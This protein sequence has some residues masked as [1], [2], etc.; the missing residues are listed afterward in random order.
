MVEAVFVRSQVARARIAHIDTATARRMPGVVTVITASDLV[1][2][3]EPFTRFVDQEETPPGLAKVANPIVLPCPIEPLASDEVRYVGQPIAVVVAESRY[4]AEDAAEVISIEYEELPVIDNPEDAVHG[5]PDLV[6]A[7]LGTNVQASFEVSVGNV[8]MAFESV[9]R[10]LSFKVHVPRLAANPIETRGVVAARDPSSGVLT[11]W[12][13]TQVPYMVRTRIAEQLHLPEET[14]RVVAPDVGGGFG[15]KVNVYPEEV[16]L[17]Y[18]ALFLDRPVRWIEDRQEHLLAAM[19]SRDQVHFVKVGFTDD[20]YI[21]AIED[22]FLLDAGAYNPFSLT[23]AYNTAAHLRGPYKVPNF[24]IKGA[25]VLTNKSPNGPYR[26]AGRP[27]A[28]FVMDKIL[29]LVAAATGL[30]PAEV[31]RRN[32][33][34]PAELPYD[35][36]MPYRD[37]A[38]I[39]YDSGDYPAALNKALELCEYDSLRADQARLKAEGRYVGVGLSFYIEG[40]GLGPFEGSTVRVEGSG[41]V[42]VHAGSTPHGQSH[43]TT[44]AQICADELGVPFASVRVRAGDT[45]LLPYGVGTFASRSLVTAGTAV[46]R[47]TKVVKDKVLAVAAELLEVNPAD[48]VIEDGVIHPLGVPSRAVD[49]KAVAKAASPGP[50]AVSIAGV[51]GGISATSY[52]VP[53]TVTFSYGV[54]AATVEVD[55]ELGTVE[56]LRYIVVHDCGRIVNPLV[57]EGQVQ[58]GVAQGIGSA[59]YEEF[60]YGSGGQ[61][62]TTTFMDYLLPGSTEIPPVTQIHLQIPSPRNELGVKG[63]GEGG[64]IP[65][66][67]AIGNA[68]IDALGA[69][70]VDLPELPFTPERISFLADKIS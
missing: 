55:P 37:G 57:V 39:I 11:V 30:D 23:C 69:A 20:G 29:A 17:P 49:L 33:I 65:P 45:G 21:V 44:L 28:V 24:H 38:R 2:K 58:G 6:H 10:T 19:H 68:I 4:I 1:G 50:R 61:P 8:E 56:I 41:E 36:G 66:P 51:E 16:V 46:A 53:E 3:V 70:A 13:S 48:L 27:E 47:A 35:Q 31:F 40:T 63:V 60:I 7:D 5:Y 54:H 12:S 9:S 64:A 15:P 42:V 52:F 34:S 22:S 59:L 32:L 67:A 26:G 62:L 25:C 43:Q 18:L 14:V